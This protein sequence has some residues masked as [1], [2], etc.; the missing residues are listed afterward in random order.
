[1]SK[2]NRFI[3]GHHLQPHSTWGKEGQY[4]GVFPYTKYKSGS[5]SM[6][7]SRSGVHKVKS[8]LAPCSCV[9]PNHQ[10]G[11][12]CPPSGPWADPAVR[13]KKRTTGAQE[14]TS[15]ESGGALTRSL[16]PRSS[17]GTPTC[18]I[19]YSKE[20]LA[21]STS[22]HVVPTALK[23]FPSTPSVPLEAGIRLA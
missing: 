13:E 15:V 16:D 10:L 6:H 5:K 1:M 22:V 21:W 19:S 7:S 18:L 11:P 9:F 3:F 14:L 4:F 20:K 17:A 2:Y 8:P 12:L 23:F